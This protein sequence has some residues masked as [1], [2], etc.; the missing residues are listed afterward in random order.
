MNKT[1]EK[2][3]TKSPVTK[4]LER[5]E[6]DI[7]SFK[8]DLVIAS[9]GINDQAGLGRITEV[10]EN[11]GRE[12]GSAICD[13][14]AAWMKEEFP[15]VQSAHSYQGI[16]CRYAYTLHL[17]AQGHLAMFR[18]LAPHFGIPKHLTYKEAN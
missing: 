4:Q 6:Q 5:M 2:L 13:H 3:R 17:N 11:F 8:P 9:F 15:A 10:R 18:E 7:L 1:F 16:F 12:S 14:Y